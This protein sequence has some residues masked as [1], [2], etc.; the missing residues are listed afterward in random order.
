MRAIVKLVAVVAVVAMFSLDRRVEF[1]LSGAALLVIV[2]VL[3]RRI[4]RSD[5]AF[6]EPIQARVTLE[7]VP[8]QAPRDLHD[9]VEGMTVPAR[10][11][12]HAAYELHQRYAPAFDRQLAVNRHIDRH[13]DD[14]RLLESQHPDFDQHRYEQAQQYARAFD[15]QLAARARQPR[16][17][18]MRAQTQAYAAVTPPRRIARGSYSQFERDE[19]A[20]KPAGW[21]PHHPPSVTGMRRVK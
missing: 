4:D 11:T 14:G 1:A 3:I 20:A 2:A 21:D 10:I 12:D 15:E 6:D 8:L 5:A 18:T 16:M 9:D 7:V 17:P 19:L 13:G